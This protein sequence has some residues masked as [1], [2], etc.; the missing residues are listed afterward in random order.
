METLQSNEIKWEQLTHQLG[1][2]FAGRAI[3]YDQK[4][5]FVYEN[6]EQLK[7]HGYFSAMIPKERVAEGSVMKKCVT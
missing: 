7:L 5:S 6:Y 4:G 1:Q 3:E 2:E